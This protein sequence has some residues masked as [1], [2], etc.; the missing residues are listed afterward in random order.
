[1]R[2][3]GERRGGVKQG[4]K[5]CAR[6]GFWLGWKGKTRMLRAIA[7]R[8]PYSSSSDMTYSRLI[9]GHWGQRMVWLAACALP[10][11]LILTSVFR[12]KLGPWLG[13]IAWVVHPAIPLALVCCGVPWWRGLRGDRYRCWWLALLAIYAT[14]LVLSGWI[15]GADR[16]HL[17][18]GLLGGPVLIAV[19]FGAMRDP[20]MRASLLSGWITGMIA[21]AVL[22]LFLYRSYFAGLMAQFPDLTSLS[23]DARV[24]ALRVPGETGLVRGF[25][26]WEFM[27]NYNKTANLL[28]L[29]LLLAGYLHVM[30]A[31]RAAWLWWGAVVTVGAMLILVFSRGTLALAGIFGAALVGV[32]LFTWKREREVARRCLAVALP[33]LALCGVSFSGP[34]FRAYWR[35]SSSFAERMVIV[36]S[37]GDQTGRETLQRQAGD[38][39]GLRVSWNKGEA[40]GSASAA[41]PFASP[42][43]SDARIT[44]SAAMHPFWG[45]GI[46]RFGPSI[47]RQPE[48]E[49][50]VAFLDAWVQG[51]VL[52][53][54]GFCGLF[55]VAG[56]AFLRT[57]WRRGLSTPLIL[58]TGL[59]LVLGCLCLREYALVYLFVQTGGAFLLA[60][61]FG[62]LFLA[63]ESQAGPVP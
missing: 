37:V 47:G 27:G 55:L 36:N 30:G 5:R 35:D 50:H 49:T 58:S 12:Y 29:T 20:A 42:A 51:G 23:W 61:G 9:G 14:G 33:C 53:F 6:R 57:A 31:R 16:R 62:L 4:R 17:L 46:G 18:P 25:Y 11:E 1:M 7:G 24:I 56:I 3:K 63:T 26:F 44:K 59:V 54:A 19:V 45:Y 13:S 15:M 8:Y 38:A 22:F 60:A 39:S 34:G 21:W 52:G 28:L 32:G 48:A 10:F 43:Q 2:Q 41:N 40:K